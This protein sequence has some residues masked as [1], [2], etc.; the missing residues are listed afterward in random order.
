MGAHPGQSRPGEWLRQQRVAFGLTQEDL[1]ERSGVSVRAIADLERGRTRKPYPSS[2]R[3]LVRALGLP[4][5]AGTEMVARYRA[6]DRGTVGAI[7]TAA[8][9]PVTALAE[10]PA[11]ESTA[12]RNT[13]AGSTTDASTTDAS[14]TDASRAD[15]S[16]TDAST[17]DASTAAPVAVP[18]QLPTRVPHFAGRA[19]ELA[20]LDSVLDE[21]A[22]DR[23]S[24]ATGVVI[25]AIGGTAGVGKTALALHWAHRVAH[26]FPDG[27][28]YA[29][30]RGFDA[31]N[32][33]PAD[34]GDVLRGF[35]DALG[36]HPERRPADVEGLAALYRS[37]L[38]GRRTLVL[39]DN[40][41]D[42]AQV[43]PLLPASPECLVIVTSRRELAALV[44]REG[45]R[46]LNLDVLSETEANELLVTRLGQERAA[47]EPWAVTELATLCARLP[48]ALSVVVARAAAAP[49]LPLSSLAAE[50]TELGGR[51]D[52]LDAGDP[53]ANVRTVLSLS[54]RHLPETSARLFRLLGLHPGPDI[55]A[56]AAASLAGLT[57]A[58]A[59]SALRDLTR[60]SLLM[61][62][63]PGRYAFHD[64]L[65]AYAAE[66][67]TSAEGV[68][69]TTRRML[70]HYLHTAH[71]AH[72]VLYPGRELI[73]LDAL[74][75]GVMVETF[76]GKASALAWLEAEYQVLLKVAD[77]A[78][79]TEF[80]AHAW[81]LPVVLWTFHN[82]CG[83]WH[84]GS[85]L[86]RLALAAARRRGDLSG[87]AHALRG[88]G[89]FA[90]SLRAF[91]EAYECLAAAQLTFRELGDDLG[92]ARTDVFYS[93]ALEFQGRS[94]EALT[95]I[96]DALRLSEAAPGDP[97]MALV[98][99]SALNSS[100]WNNVQLGDLSEA[101]AFCLQAIDLCQAIGYSP[102]EAG[103]WDTLG[104]VSQRLGAHAE[105]VP[106]FLRAITLDRE[107][108]NR[109]DLAMVLA[110]LGETYLLVGDVRGAR[111]AWDESLLIL[112][113]L[114]H[115]AASEIRGRL[116][117]LTARP[118]SAMAD[119]VAGQVTGSPAAADAGAA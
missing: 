23:S 118:A 39:L 70:D 22:S 67:G 14:T 1:A 57:A 73:G 24:G 55:S 19:G 112:R 96:G 69:N 95:V 43:R 46:L 94:A 77:L 97:N 33:S 93:Q 105:A 75:P 99:A 48:L 111:E 85:R 21:A 119:P 4:D 91:D 113:T 56:A 98:R 26:R 64:L 116:T 7:G 80:D 104:V 13:A 102:G 79:R 45:A 2:V 103:T 109:Y 72:R 74:A 61:E 15:A 8:I 49:N 58:Q 84:D 11:A 27:Q 117:A 62:V 100:A 107:M 71:R 92:L 83:H 17:T 50:L 30:L 87:Q 63:V 81:R 5:A 20:L 78:E 41:A 110:H 12:T 90:I 28:L 37:V 114:H 38:A 32:G 35:L 66:Q 36:V 42:A 47:A 89:S 101:R 40:A 88:L 44:A 65:R 3:A 9:A 16:T 86:H 82:V 59:R 106:C 68:A 29:N 31:A 53:A 6:A 10:S 51:L 34:P 115:P 108:G 54:Y 76:S 18:R 52:A 60:A 25:S